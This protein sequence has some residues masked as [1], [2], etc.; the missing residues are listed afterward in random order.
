MGLDK[1]NLKRE[2]HT[3]EDNVIDEL[4]VPCLKE[5]TSYDRITGFF[6]GITFQMLA[7]GLA[8]LIT[9]GGKMRMIISTRLSESEENAIQQGY[10][11]R[12]IVEQ[13]FLARFED[14]K[15]EFEKGYLSLLTYLI[16]NNILDIRVAVVR[17]NLPKAM[18]HEKIGIFN[19]GMGNSVAFSGSGN[20]TPYGLIHN[21]ENYDVYCAWK[22]EDPAARIMGKQFYFNKLWN[23]RY[24]N[25]FTYPFPEAVKAKIFEYQDYLSKAELAQL[26]KKYIAKLKE[27]EI[28][29]QLD[30]LPSVGSIKFHDY[31]FDAIDKFQSNGYRGY[32]DMATGTGKTYTALG[33]ITRLVHDQSVKTKAFFCVIVVP[34]QHL[35]TQWEGDCKKFHI[36]PLLAFGDSKKWKSKFEQKVIST[37]LRQSKFECII[38]TTNSLQHPF[39]LD[40]LDRIK[41]RVIFVADEAHNLGAGKISRVLDM[42]F[43]YRLGLSATIERHRDASGTQKLLNFFGECC[44]HYDLGRAIEERHLSHYRYYPVLVWLD[45]DEVDEYINLSRKI[46]KWS[47]FGEDG[48][49]SEVLKKLLLRRALI[50]SGCRMKIDKLKEVIEPFK[51]DYYNLVYCG[52]VSY[53][54]YCDDVEE[55]QLNKVLK[56]L[57]Q[58]LGMIPERFTAKENMED[59]ETIKRHFEDKVINA[60]V[61][62]K[63][64]DEG[65]NIPCIQRAFILASST[66]PKE[67][68]QR[69]GRVLRLFDPKEKP[70]AEIYDFV[71][72]SRPLDKL[73]LLSEEQRK[74]E[75]RLAR[76]ELSRVEEFSRLA[77]N[78][79]E[80]NLIKQQII[81]A[82]GLDKFEYDDLEGENDE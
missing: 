7:P 14:P 52:A 23:G 11:E 43:K 74:I 45:D 4:F 13:D 15:D 65:V 49:E 44:I 66:N 50:V 28:G 63:C 9:S 69:R 10:N 58:D 6:S 5:A 79:Y 62:I 40:A 47:S 25:V 78:Y 1:L 21:S 70:Y 3:I 12:K 75:A 37:E 59:R 72:L 73:G 76:R 38:I 20:E 36:E 61:A 33:S 24:P 60:I 19:D 8:P 54:H 77:D 2:Y 18:E 35:V 55:T 56:M 16:A 82:Y 46:S 67:Y 32:F 64:L 71:T 31:Q 29:I 81:S 51:N 68:I 22:G 34:Y 27:R 39:V 53:S 42:D 26:D 80:S 30:P 48:E 57:K 41:K 17:P